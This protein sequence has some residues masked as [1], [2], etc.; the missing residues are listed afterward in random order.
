MSDLVKRAMGSPWVSGVSLLLAVVGIVFGVFTYWTSQKERELVFTVNP[1]RTTVVSAGQATELE[2]L[3]RGKPVS[4]SDITAVQIAIW[5][6]GKQSIRP[7][8]VLDGISIFTQP[9][10]PILEASI[11]KRS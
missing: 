2:V 7:E 6:A 11:R 3:H 5:N 10:V 9:P 8:N 1:V 4:G